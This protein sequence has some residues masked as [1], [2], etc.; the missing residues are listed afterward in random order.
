M[1]KHLRF[2][3]DVAPPAAESND[4]WQLRD[5]IAFI[6]RHWILVLCMAALGLLGGFV[7]LSTVTPLFTA[8]TQILLDPQSDRAPVQ[9]PNATVITA[10][11]PAALDNQIAVIRSDGL[12]ARVV[13]R[14]NLAPR[15]DV[16][17]AAASE[18]GEPQRA[19]DPAA[20]AKANEASKDGAVARLRKALEVKRSGVG[21]IISVSITDPSAEKSAELANAVA[22]TFILSKL[23]SRFDSAK[24]AS[25]W[26]SDRLAELKE[27]L[28]LSEEAVS[29]FRIEHN[30]VTGVS[31]VT[32]TEQQ[33]SDL[34]TKLIEARA[35]T[36]AKKAR[37]EFLEKAL[38]G[39]S[40]AGLPTIF[41][42]SAML[43]LQQ[44]LTDV[45]QKEADLLARY[46]ARYPATINVQ[47]EK[48]DIE[49]AIDVEAKRQIATIKTEY[50]LAQAREQ[51][52]EEALKE[53]T[54]QTGSDDKIS[55][56]LRQLERTAAVNK[57]LFEE[58]L[59]KARIADNTSTFEVRDA[60]V[61]TSAKV[62]NLPE[63]PKRTNTLASALLIGLGIGLVCAFAVDKLNAGFMTP[64]QVEE[65]LQLPLLASVKRLGAAERTVDGKRL[66]LP[67]YVYQRPLSGF[68]EAIRSLRTAIKMTDVD[69]PPKIIL[70]TSTR[71]GEGKTTT[72]ICLAVSAAQAGLKA[73]IIDAD[74]RHNSCS[75]FFGKQ[76][77]KGLV[78][79]LGEDTDLREAITRDEGTGVMVLPAGSATQNPPDLLG[80]E[81]MKVLIETFRST[82]DLVIVDSPP[83]GPVIDPQVISL[84]CD[85]VLFVVQWAT[86]AREVVQ[87]SLEKFPDPR[88]IGGV[89]LTMVNEQRAQKYGSYG[90]GYYY[91]RKYYGKYYSS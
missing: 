74:F 68:A 34:N 81:K 29:Q 30:L 27:Q 80:S 13:Q 82:F 72:A 52:T 41:Q 5:K 24:R 64:R 42:S 67:V 60:I 76:K 62:P 44:R 18:A 49:R 78:D 33:L 86:T 77:A 8:S 16:P 43:A 46:T 31:K 15:V 3:A 36:N 71:P 66:S 17:A 39:G 25:G 51:Q 48:R 87:S 85:K 26:L 57:V 32:L 14:K 54:G 19:P 84:I 89:V 53:A 70:V 2:S 38:T 79:I 1:N 6:W 11:D 58:F 7:F 28:R 10:I 9:G 40:Y 45:S 47:A 50:A 75:K 56:E 35:D 59:Q 88:K 23:D 22:D 61:L 63:F 83:V 37:V 20:V 12:L 90:S 73:L 21:Y 65:Q 69:H 91:G 55:I 4:S